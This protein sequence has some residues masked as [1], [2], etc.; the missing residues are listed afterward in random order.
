MT[1]CTSYPIHVYHR[2]IG[3]LYD[4]GFTGTTFMIIKSSDQSI[5]QSLKSVYPRVVWIEDKLEQKSHLNIHRFLVMKE[6]LKTNLIQSDYVFLCDSRDV[7]FQKNFEHYPLDETVDLFGF[8]ENQTFQDD[9]VYNPSWVRQLERYLQI[10]ILDRIANNAIIC[11]GTTLGKTKAISRYIH[12]MCDHILDYQI[13][14]N[15]DQAMHNYYLYCNVLY[16]LSIRLL[17]N[18]DNLVN[19]VGASVPR[20]VQRHIVNE[21]D[22]DISWIVHQYDRYPKKMLEQLSVKYLFTS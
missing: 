6:V 9:L 7:L 17:S 4:T 22:D 13:T 5:I 11:C 14:N 20:I 21:K 10:S 12:Q 8:L 16:P 19:T 1:Y 2:F 18:D 3:S 15:L